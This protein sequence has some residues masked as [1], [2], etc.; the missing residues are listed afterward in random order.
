MLS[1][2]YPKINLQV[3]S[4]QSET[5]LITQVKEAVQRAGPTDLPRSLTPALN[6]SRERAFQVQRFIRVLSS[7]H[8]CS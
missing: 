6:D 1:L 5:L 4:P 7:G 3:T 8:I 2:E